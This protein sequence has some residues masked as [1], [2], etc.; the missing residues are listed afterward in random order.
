MTVRQILAIGF[1]ICM[2]L[3]APA[4]ATNPTAP[5]FTWTNNGSTV[6]L[7][8][9]RGQI[10][11]VNFFATWCPACRWEAQAFVS[12]SH[13]YASRG[14]TF[15]GVDVGDESIKTVTDYAQKNGVDYQLVVDSRSIL[16][17]EYRI[18]VLPTTV[19]VGSHGEVINRIVGGLS[20]ADLASA[21]NA[22]L[23]GH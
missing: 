11:V 13:D 21:L 20:Y 4:S 10:V 2:L 7:Y 5:D 18:G 3:G 22:T 16:N 1:V 8:N 12:A 9:L 14:V 17:D 6:H 19:L 23:S 15:V